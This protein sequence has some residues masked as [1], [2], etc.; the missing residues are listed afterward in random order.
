MTDSGHRPAFT[1]RLLAGVSLGILWYSIVSILVVGVF[2]LS[3]RLGPL[4]GIETS[5]AIGFSLTVAAFAIGY[6]RSR[7]IDSHTEETR[8]RVWT[9]AFVLSFGGVFA[10]AS[11]VATM[12][13]PPDFYQ[14]TVAYGGVHLVAVTVAVITAQWRSQSQSTDE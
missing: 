2:L 6:Y 10:I 12:T 9:I 14:L 5:A 4:P 7:R 3:Q 1:S 11:I 13:V 8:V